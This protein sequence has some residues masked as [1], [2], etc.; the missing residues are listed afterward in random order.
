MKELFNH[1]NEF[2]SDPLTYFKLIISDT[3]KTEAL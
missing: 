1:T 3:Q 2:I